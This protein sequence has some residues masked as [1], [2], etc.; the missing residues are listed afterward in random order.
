MLS[1]A[2]A[3]VTRMM[4]SLPETVQIQVMEHL[5]DYI[6]DL[7]DEG[8]WDVS[9]KKTQRELAAAAQRTKQEIANG[10]AKPMDYDR[11]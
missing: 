2:I 3:T 6:E 4:E 5:R 7:Q 8:R 10:Q 11:L 9:F 1:T